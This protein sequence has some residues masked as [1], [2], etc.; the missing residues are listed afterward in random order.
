MAQDLSIECRDA[1]YFITARTMCSRLWFVNNKRLQETILAYLAKFAEE[2]SAKLYG[3]TLMGNHYHLLASFPLANRA[4]FLR[5]FN[6]VIAT[7]TNA[8]VA[9]YEGG[10]LWGRRARAQLLPNPE[11]VEHYFFYAALNPVSSGLC[12]RL[13]DF[14]GYS[15]FS[16]SI[17]NRERE[18]QLVNFAEYNSRKRFNPHLTIQECTKTYYL[19]FERLP[20]LEHLS[21]ADYRVLMLESLEERRQRA[22]AARVAS[23]GG[24]ATR[25]QLRAT[26]PGTRP[27]HSKQS[28]RD[29]YR[30]LCLTLCAQTRARV[31][32]W[33]FAIRDAYREASKRFRAG[34]LTVAFPPGTYRPHLRVPAT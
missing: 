33:Y 32:E 5:A 27:H 8:L 20:G 13:S 24:F 25:S 30:P 29:S 34:D 12:Q 23:G 16:D 22:V 17:S 11:D 21:S 10:K 6:S 2:F 31:T 26:K 7:K 19:R 14:D 9:A 15:S 4:D 18:F 3:F 28:A 1:I